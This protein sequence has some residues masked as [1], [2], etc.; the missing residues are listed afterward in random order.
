MGAAS[1]PVSLE[2]DTES[3]TR[4]TVGNQPVVDSPIQAFNP[5]L[6]GLF[7]GAPAE[8]PDSVA[9]YLSSP[10]LKAPV[11]QRAQRAYG[12]RASQQIVMRARVLQR[13]CTCG[14]TCAKCQEDEERRS[15]QRKS[16]SDASPGIDAIPT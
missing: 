11:L 8:P 2:K 10:G 14:G 1:E 15:V 9:R 16:T 4:E 7:H 6:D 5:F 3:R 12:N 13:Q